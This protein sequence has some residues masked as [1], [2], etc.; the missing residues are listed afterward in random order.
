MITSI[1]NNENTTKLLNLLKRS[2]R[3]Y[4]CLSKDEEQALIEKYKDDIIK[5]VKDITS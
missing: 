1:Q 3:Q 5:R 2:E 4:P